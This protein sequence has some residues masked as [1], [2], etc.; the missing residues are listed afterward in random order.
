LLYDLPHLSAADL[1]GR[2][3]HPRERRAYRVRELDVAEPNDTKRGRVGQPLL[4]DDELRENAATDTLLA[5]YIGVSRD[6][7][8]PRW[9]DGS[10]DLELEE[11]LRRRA[12]RELPREVVAEGNGE[13]V[14]H[15]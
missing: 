15:V 1:C 5:Q 10:I 7:A 9:Y 12:D 11:R 13:R 2:E 3:P 4:I 6:L 14:A 8:S